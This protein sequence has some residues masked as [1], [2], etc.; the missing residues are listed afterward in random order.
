[1]QELVHLARARVVVEVEMQAE[2]C[3]MGFGS[4]SSFSGTGLL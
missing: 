4:F 2:D 1:M 3:C